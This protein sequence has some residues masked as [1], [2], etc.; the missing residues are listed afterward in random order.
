MDITIPA[1]LEVKRDMFKFAVECNYSEFVAALMRERDPTREAEMN[2]FLGSNLERWRSSPQMT[3]GTM[4][5]V[6]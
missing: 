3:L 4:F 6:A 5:R 2:R 1:Y